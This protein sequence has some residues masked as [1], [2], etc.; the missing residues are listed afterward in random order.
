[1][2]GRCQTQLPYKVASVDLY[3]DYGEDGVPD[4][5]V[6]RGKGRSPEAA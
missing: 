5:G 4:E 3:A 2:R 1:M 6:T